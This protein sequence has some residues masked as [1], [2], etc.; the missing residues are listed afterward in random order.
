VQIEQ[1]SATALRFVCTNADAAKKTIMQQC[2][3]LDLDIT[4]IQTET[5]SLENL[6]RTLTTQA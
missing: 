1:V 5:Q 2:L 6:F 4:S 3:N